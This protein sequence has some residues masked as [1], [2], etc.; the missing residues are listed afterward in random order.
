MCWAM[1]K[2]A[3]DCASEQNLAPLVDILEQSWW[4]RIS[5]VHLKDPIKN[6]LVD[7]EEAIMFWSIVMVPWCFHLVVT[8]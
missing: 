8:K 4:Q 3:S 7:Q 5:Q 1:S 2:L 6:M